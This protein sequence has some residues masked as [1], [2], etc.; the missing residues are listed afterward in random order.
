MKHT[1]DASGQK[2]GRVA[3]QVASLL[4]GKNSTAFK[5]NVLADVH[6]EIVNAS[7]VDVT[8]K[9]MKE[10]EYAIY[11]GH[12]G[13]LRQESWERRSEKKGYAGIFETVIKRMLPPNKLRPEM[14]KR[15]TIS[16]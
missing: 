10:K 14:L 7:K 16:E 12:P 4:M 3:T 5:R 15:L 8:P 11:S 1:I 2:I 6:V 13:G 9:K